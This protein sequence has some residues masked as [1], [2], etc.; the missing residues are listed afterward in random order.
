[1]SAPLVEYGPRAALHW[2]EIEDI[3]RRARRIM[4]EYPRRHSGDGG[5]QQH[6][7]ALTLDYNINLRTLYRYLH[8]GPSIAVRVGPWT[9]YFAERGKGHPAQVGGWVHDDEVPA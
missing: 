6:L 7:Y 9:G 8:F 2:T 4:L 5:R 3:T 1:M